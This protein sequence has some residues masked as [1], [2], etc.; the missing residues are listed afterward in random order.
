MQRFVIALATTLAVT[1]SA[2]SAMQATDLDIDGDGFASVSEV[3]AVFPGF[4][5]SDF[6]SLDTND[7][8]RLSSN[9]L[10]TSGTA[11]II[12]KYE[13]SMSIVHGLSDVDQDGDRFA[14][15]EELGV[16]YEGLLD[17]EFRQIDVNR[18]NR[19][20][21]S[22]LYAPRAQALVTRYEMADRMLVTIMDVDTNDDFFATYEELAQ[23]FPGLSRVDFEIIDANGDNRV[24]SNEYYN[25]DAQAILDRK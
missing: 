19:V 8:R 9:E 17:S 20:N 22:E 4:T 21:A 1:A 10:K 14:S 5:S 16:V 7:D 2:A 6:R 24:A 12:K 25:A 18:D 15:F 3:R 23:S 11:G 13:S